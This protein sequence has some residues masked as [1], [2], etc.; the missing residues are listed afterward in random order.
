M[1]YS[2]YITCYKEKA[3]ILQPGD[4]VKLVYGDEVYGV[5]EVA[6]IYEPNKRK[7]A[8]LV[9]GTED[10]AHPGVQKLFDRPA[11]YVGGKIT[12]I[13]RLT[14]KFPAY[15]FDPVETRQLFADKGWKTIVG[16]QTRNPVH[17]AHEYI[18]KAALETIDGLFLNP[19]VGET[20]SDD[21]SAAIRMESYEVLLKTIILKVVYN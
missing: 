5:I 11:I 21:V 1:E 15:S 16:F 8:L 2:D 9:Y 17:R 4:E 14:Q 6:D 10:L 3:S 12:L 13:K 20:K 19:L 7:E 18:Q